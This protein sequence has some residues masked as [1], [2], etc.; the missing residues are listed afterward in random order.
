MSAIPSSPPSTPSRRTRSN[1]LPANNLAL[2]D[3]R[4]VNLKADQV[5]SMTIT[6]GTGPA[7]TLLRS[8]GGTW[9]ASNVRDRMV[10]ST[11]ADTQASL[12]CQLQAQ[13]WLGPALPAYGLNKPVLSIA[14]LADQ[15]RPTILRIGA[16]LPNGTHAAQIEATRHLRHLRR[17]LRHPQRQ[18]APAHSQGTARHQRA[19]LSQARDQ[20]LGRF[21]KAV[22]AVAA[23][24]DRR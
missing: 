1:F 16:A 12:F 6:A 11:K 21:R 13:T 4:A 20:R 14:V 3:P 10:D 2:R 7:V 24:Y 17:R 18:L 9:T 15:P 23:V 8:P 22:A 19:R 5:K